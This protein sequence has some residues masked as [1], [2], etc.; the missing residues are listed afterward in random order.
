MGSCYKTT[1]GLD[2]EG[3]FS[4]IRVQFGRGCVLDDITLVSQVD[5]GSSLSCELFSY[6]QRLIP[7]FEAFI[8]LEGPLEKRSAPN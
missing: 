5:L 3:L 2:L 6:G 7:Q 4:E 1:F 8:T